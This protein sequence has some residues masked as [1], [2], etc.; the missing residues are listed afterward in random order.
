M[1]PVAAEGAVGWAPPLPPG[2]ARGARDGGKGGGGGVTDS[3]SL[4]NFLTC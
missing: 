2:A 3:V 4:G 1:D